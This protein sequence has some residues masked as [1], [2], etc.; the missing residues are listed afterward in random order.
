MQEK[1]EFLAAISS[2]C[3]ALKGFLRKVPEGKE[4]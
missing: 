2:L 3:S 4:R 1:E